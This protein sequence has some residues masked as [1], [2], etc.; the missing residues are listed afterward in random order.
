M[1]SLK[2]VGTAV[3]AAQIGCVGGAWD[4]RQ[5]IR[6]DGFDAQR[7]H[8]LDNLLSAIQDRCEGH[9]I[10]FLLVRVADCKV[11]KRISLQS[12]L[13]NTGVA[14]IWIEFRDCHQNFLRR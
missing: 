10:L 7:T 9:P 5:D 4:N 8:F 1:R 13:K 12:R 14:T 2:T 3:P 11:T 6:E